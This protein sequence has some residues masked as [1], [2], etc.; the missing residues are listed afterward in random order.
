MKRLFI[1][2]ALMLMLLSTLSFGQ[3]TDEQPQG[4]EEQ[5]RYRHYKHE[6]GEGYHI[7]TIFSNNGPRSSGGYIA[8]SNKLTAINGD[9]ANLV[10]MYGG[11]YIGH[12]FLIGVGGAATTNYIPVPM[13]YSVNPNGRMTYEYAQAGLMTEYVIASDR[14]I[15]VAFQLFAGAGF[16]MQYD[17]HAWAHDSYWNTYEDYDH[18]ENFFAVAE[19]GVKVEVNVF[20]WLRFSPGI[21]YR[22]AYGSD[23]IGLPDSAIEGTSVNLTLKIGKF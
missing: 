16:T 7:K 13:E 1:P 21:S 12:R 9:Y 17:W 22:L 4:D 14:A 3:Q 2:T 19:P 11:W 5:K 18:N 15:H 23:G 20:R 8:F 10:E 6:R